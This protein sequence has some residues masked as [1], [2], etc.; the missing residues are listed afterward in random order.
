MKD[1]R[2]VPRL[3]CL[4]GS[5]SFCWNALGTGGVRVEGWFPQLDGELQGPSGS[6]PSFWTSILVS[7]LRDLLTVT[8]LSLVSHS[9]H[10]RAEAGGVSWLHLALS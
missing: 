2:I 6:S 3:A 9:F 5:E 8:H 4:V 1:H 7:M 10:K